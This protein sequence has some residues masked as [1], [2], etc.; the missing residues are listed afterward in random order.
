MSARS[1]AGLMKPG[2]VCVSA[3]EVDGRLIRV[4]DLGRDYRG[5]GSVVHA[6]RA[7]TL[8]VAAGE[9]VAVIGP[10]GSGKSTLLQILGLLDRPT[11]GSYFL[12]QQDIGQLDADARARIRNQRIGFIFQD[13]NLLPRANALENVELPLL[14]AAVTKRERRQRARQA[15]EAVGLGHRLA[16]VPSELSGGEQQRVAIARAMVNGP[17]LVLA[18]EPTGALDNRTG[19]EMLQLLRDLNRRGITVIVVT[20]DAAVADHARRIVRLSDGCLIKD[21][22]AEGSVPTRNP[23]RP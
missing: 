16:H 17:E 8:E 14:Y 19:Q 20:H 10:S 18:D 15:L 4:R 13:F 1:L 11:A 6:L 3:S 12:G 9:F 21:S 5:G 22:G 2:S 7:I 23:E